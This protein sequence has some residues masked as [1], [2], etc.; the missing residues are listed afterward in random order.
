MNEFDI[1]HA[2][3]GTWPGPEVRASTWIY[4]VGQIMHFIGLSMLLGSLFIVDLRL[5]GFFRRV[6]IQAALAFLP[7]AVIGFLINL[8]TGL[9]FFFADPFLFWPNPAFKVKLVLILL[10][11][12]NAM[13]FTFLGHSKV[14]RL[15]DGADTNFATKVTA[16][17]SL[18]LWFAVLLFGRLI[19]AFHGSTNLFQ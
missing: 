12:T 19:P 2:I 16:S 10:A 3:K 14:Q 13:L 15:A 6:P 4:A 8:T 7:W 17:L 1:L 11:G 5:L 18:T 9:I